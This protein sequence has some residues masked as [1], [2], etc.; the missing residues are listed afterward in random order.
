VHAPSDHTPDRRVAVLGLQ[1]P[2]KAG[3][4]VGK[5]V[6]RFERL[7]EARHHRTVHRALREPDAELR[8]VVLDGSVHGDIRVGCQSDALF[9]AG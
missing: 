4:F 5:R 7:F 2:D 9:H 6:D 1:P 3:G 8:E